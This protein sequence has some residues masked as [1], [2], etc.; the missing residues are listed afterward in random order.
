MLEWKFAYGYNAV[1]KG[2]SYEISLKPLPQRPGVL[3][4]G[5]DGGLQFFIE[6]NGEMA[7]C[8]KIYVNSTDRLIGL[9]KVHYVELYGVTEE[10]GKDVCER[11]EV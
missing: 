11:I 4:V 1:R 7:I 8:R 5:K 2:D 6:I 10:G 9:P 3:R